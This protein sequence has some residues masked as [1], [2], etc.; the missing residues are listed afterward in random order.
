[1]RFLRITVF[2]FFHST[3]ST[4][5]PSQRSRQWLADLTDAFKSLLD[6]SS[7]TTV[8]P[9]STCLPKFNPPDCVALRKKQICTSEVK[10]RS[11]FNGDFRLAKPK[12]LLRVKKCYV[13]VELRTTKPKCSVLHVLISKS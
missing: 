1:M 12:K 4:D 7:N 11:G 5:C 13:R 10:Y 6:E 9:R 3:S 2:L 8:I